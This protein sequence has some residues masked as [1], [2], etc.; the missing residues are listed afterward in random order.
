VYRLLIAHIDLGLAVQIAG[1][2]H[3]IARQ[4]RQ[5]GEAR[6]DFRKQFFTDIV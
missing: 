6:A 3:F 1:E 5:V 4:F 2:A